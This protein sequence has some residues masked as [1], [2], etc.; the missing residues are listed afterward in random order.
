MRKSE[1]AGV[2]VVLGILYGAILAASMDA[3][4]LAS[5][6]LYGNQYLIPVGTAMFTG[7]LAYVVVISYEDWVPYAQER[8]LIMAGGLN[9][10]EGPEEEDWLME[11]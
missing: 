4:A 11:E 6:I 5:W 10:E 8:L 9:K 3:L 2:G 7:L 1:A